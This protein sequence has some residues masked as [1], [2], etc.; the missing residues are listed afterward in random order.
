MKVII[1]IK[2]LETLSPKNP[3]ITP[4]PLN[5]DIK[6]IILVNQKAAHE[7][8]RYFHTKKQHCTTRFR[9]KT[10]NKKGFYFLKSY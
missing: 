7:L 6:R 10:K 5:A 8:G 2:L 1:D 9:Q 4:S 3:C